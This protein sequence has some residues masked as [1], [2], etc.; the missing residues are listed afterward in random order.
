MFLF[1]S[2]PEEVQSDDQPNAEVE[3]FYANQEEDPRYAYYGFDLLIGEFD[4]WLK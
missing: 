3:P 4:H 2:D 1:N